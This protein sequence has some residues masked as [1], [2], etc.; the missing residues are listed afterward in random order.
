MKVQKRDSR[1]EDVAFDKITRRISILCNGLSPSIDPSV[2]AYSTIKKMYDGISTAEI[3]TIS[4]RDA[5]DNKLV[6]PD[7]SILAAR[8]LVSNLHKL[9]CDT[10]SDCMQTVHEAIA[11]FSE[12][13]IRFIRKHASDLNRMIR[14]DADYDF[15]YFGFK[16][17]ENNYLLKIPVEGQR[18]KMRVCDRPQYMFMRVAIAIHMDAQDDGCLKD[19]QETYSLLSHMMFTHAT[20]TLFNACNKTQQL[21]SCFLLGTHD[22]IEGIM[23]NLSDSAFISKY[24][25][26]IGIHMHNIRSRDQLIH[27]TNGRSTG[28][29]PQLKIYNETAR[30]FNQGGKRMGAFA[31]YLEPWHGDIMR[32]LQMKLAQGA[33]SER[34]R[35]LFYALWVPDLFMQRAE[36]GASW[37]LF[38]EDEAP[39]LSSLYD[40]MQVCTKCNLCLND[41]YNRYHSPCIATDTKC[42][43]TFTACNAFSDVYTRYEKEDRGVGKVAARDV[44]DAIFVMQRESGTPYICYKDHVNRQ[45]NQQNIGTIKSSNLCSEIMEYS[46]AKSYA[47]CTLAS[48]NL[49]KFVL[50]RASDGSLHVDHTALHSIVRHITRNLDKIIDRNMYPVSKCESN[51]RNYRPIGIGVQ[52]LAD[53]FIALR[54]PFLSDEAATIDRELFETIYHATLTESNARARQYG[55]YDGFEGSPASQGKLQ[56]DLWSESTGQSVPLSTERYDWDGLKREIQTTGLRNSLHV[57]LM[58]TVSTSQIMGNNESFEPYASNIYTKSTLAGK[59]VVS[60]K[61]MIYHLMEL[62]LWN[63]SIK[64]RIMDD[65]GML[66]HIDSIPKEVRDIYTTVWEMKQS[67]LMERAAVRSAFVDQSQSLNIH[68]KKNANSVLRGVMLKGWKLGLKTGSYYIRTQP[69]AKAMKNNIASKEAEPETDGEACTRDCLSC[70]S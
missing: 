69:A 14:I 26:G 33:D 27:G 10:F 6:H 64:R 68:A 46:D 40:G 45:S 18:L 65:D 12:E 62:G 56:F 47:C 61:A 22:S 19:I 60:N 13:H 52:G 5:E 35:D 59:F 44:W 34:A 29:V 57:A 70:G 4:A 36:A 37:T 66:T 53:L 38:S 55:A 49:K 51:S 30:T 54:V 58:P 17:L 16:T 1:F 3:D 9:T 20:P 41:A 11:I 24:A 31:V 39:G 21:N 42:H 2:I 50:P 32:F 63:S 23:Q 67:A 15:D 48:I 28:L 8:I 43:H 7:F 25:G